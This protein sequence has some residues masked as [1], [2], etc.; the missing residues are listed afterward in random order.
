M[1]GWAVDRLFTTATSRRAPGA[2][3]ALIAVYALALP[4]FE[5]TH[6]LIRRARLPLRGLAYGLGFLAAE[7]ALATVMTSTFGR[8]PWDYRGTRW[9]VRGRT[10]LD[11]APLW[12]VAG[13]AL[14]R[15]HDA[16]T[17]A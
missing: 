12:A 3:L 9:S 1:T 4:L 7:Y 6:D 16:L 10:R 2:Q 13:L 14:E 15:V 17:A 5:P 8:A 11:Y